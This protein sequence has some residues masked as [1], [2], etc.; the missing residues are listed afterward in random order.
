MCG[1]AGVSHTVHHFRPSIQAYAP[2]KCQVVNLSSISRH[3]QLPTTIISVLVVYLEQTRI[4]VALMA[5][6]KFNALITHQFNNCALPVASIHAMLH[7][8]IVRQLKEL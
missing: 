6:Y 7:L 2:Y 8:T 1:P 5:I 3:C 4:K